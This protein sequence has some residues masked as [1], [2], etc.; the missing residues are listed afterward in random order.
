MGVCKT[1]INEIQNNII[2]MEFISIFYFFVTSK[3][4]FFKT[5]KVRKT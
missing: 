1:H 3:E 4:Q 2:V 5:L